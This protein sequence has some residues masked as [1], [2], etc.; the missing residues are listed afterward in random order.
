MWCKQI[1]QGVREKSRVMCICLH[2][3]ARSLVGI[4]ICA[5]SNKPTTRKCETVGR[6]FPRMC[7][8]RRLSWIYHVQIRMAVNE[9]KRGNGTGPELTRLP[10]QLNLGSARRDIGSTVARA[11]ER[12]YVL[13]G[14]VLQ[15]KG[16]PAG[17]V[18]ATR[19]CARLGEEATCCPAKAARTSCTGHRLN[20][21]PTELGRDQRTRQVLAEKRSQKAHLPP[22]GNTDEI[23]T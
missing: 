18:P 6:K 22:N 4:W 12:V 1:V 8:R 16:F 2:F 23:K 11:W 5:L 13:Y 9:R 17:A 21:C 10:C 20:S 3:Q 14:A 15:M 7:N 19:V